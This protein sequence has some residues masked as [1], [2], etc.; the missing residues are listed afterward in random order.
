MIFSGIFLKG[1]LL[2]D[3]YTYCLKCKVS[4]HDRMSNLDGKEMEDFV[5]LIFNYLQ[6]SY[7]KSES[8]IASQVKARMYL[9]KVLVKSAVFLH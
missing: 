7:Y 9:F 1:F 6:Y 3:H 8:K 5:A 4:C 2:I